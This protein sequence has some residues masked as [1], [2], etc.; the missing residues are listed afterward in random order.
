MHAIYCYLCVQIWNVVGTKRRFFHQPQ[1][2]SRTVR[3]VVQVSN[4]WCGFKQ[5]MHT[6]IYRQFTVPF[7]KS[8]N[9]CIH[10]NC[11]MSVQIFCFTQRSPVRNQFTLLEYPVRRLGH[12]EQYCLITDVWKLSE[13]YIFSRKGG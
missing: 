13:W 8:I 7:F 10:S 1:A 11:C 9:Y 6:S 12:F 4:W 3:I 2:L 5:S